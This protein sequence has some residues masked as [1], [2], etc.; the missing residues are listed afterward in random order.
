MSRQLWAK[1]QTKKE[2]TQQFLHFAVCPKDFLSKYLYM[3]CD[4]SFMRFY[5]LVNHHP[6]IQKWLAQLG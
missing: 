6:K 4:L 1:L 2:E 5:Q 3:Y